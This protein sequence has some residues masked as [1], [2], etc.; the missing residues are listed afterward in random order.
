M[1]LSSDEIRAL[2]AEAGPLV[3]GA[4]VENVHACD[5]HAVIL[6]LFSPSAGKL[7]LLLSARPGLSR[8]HLVW[9]RPQ[10]LPT[11]PPFS[12]AARKHLKG[13]RLE[14]VRQVSGDRVLELSFAAKEGALSLVLEMASSRG[15]L[16]LVGPDRRILATLHSLRR[17]PRELSVGEAYRFP[18]A[19]AQPSLLKSI[20]ENPWRYLQPTVDSAP[21]E[22]NA[23]LHFALGAHYFRLERESV[24]R[25]RKA[26]LS[27]SLRKGIAKRSELLRKV[28]EDLARAEAGEELRQKGELLKGAFGRLRRGMSSIELPDYFQPGCENVQIELDPALGP[29]KNVERYFKRYKKARRAV[30]FLRERL[31]LKEK[32]L[33][34]VR[35]LLDLLEASDDLDGVS[36]I[37]AEAKPFLARASTRKPKEAKPA[38]PRGPRR[39][40][41]TGGFEILVGDRKS[42][43]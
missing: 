36:R 34:R 12:E 13:S 20:T 2:V 4:F 41:S 29:E 9:E 19:K 5:E 10:A 27:S 14:S 6:T 1:S 31:A 35:E 33:G 3:K 25:E 38:P 7:F 32:E 11:P 18:E 42:V 30:P 43:V 39:F 23:P 28:H 37:E 17:G 21:P 26:A 15:Q 40:L 22:P 8:F 24:L 16:V